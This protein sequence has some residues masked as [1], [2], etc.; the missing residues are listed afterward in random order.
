MTTATLIL[1]ALATMPAP[2]SM[3]CAALAPSA[4]VAAEAHRHAPATVL[5]IAYVE[6]RCNP[7]A[8]GS[9]R[10]QGAWQVLPAYAQT[11][12]DADDGARMLKRWKRRSRGALLSAVRAYNAGSKGLSGVAGNGYAARVLAVAGRL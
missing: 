12:G 5:A 8:V 1:A 7:R 6:S 2:V 10:E 3:R 4:V 11:H 9:L